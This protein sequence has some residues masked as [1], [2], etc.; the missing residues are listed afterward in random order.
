M[1]VEDWAPRANSAS[2]G[3]TR[4]P[5][6]QSVALLEVCGQWIRLAAATPRS[7]PLPS[8]RSDVTA[9]MGRVLDDPS[10]GVT[11]CGSITH[12]ICQHPKEEGPRRSGGLLRSQVEAL[13][14]R[15][16]GRGRTADLSLFR[17]SLVP[18][19]LPAR[20]SAPY[21]RGAGASE[22]TCFAA[23]RAAH[24]CWARAAR[25]WPPSSSGPG[26]RPFTAVAPVRIRLGVPGRR[27]ARCGARERGRT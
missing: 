23:V 4:G 2:G 18:T 11:Q 9:L 25:R 7:A 20:A 1:V 15:G 5:M 8:T 24:L 21:N 19:E 10:R 17:R 27:A 16:Q 6:R 26:P 14:A 22:S 13:L 12:E 3:R